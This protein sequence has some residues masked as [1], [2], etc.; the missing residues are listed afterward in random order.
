MS[1]PLTIGLAIGIPFIAVPIILVT[2]EL[3]KKKH[4][5]PTPSSSPNEFWTP[6]PTYSDDSTKN[7]VAIF[8]KK[9]RTSFTYVYWDTKTAIKSFRKNPSDAINKSLYNIRRSIKS[10]SQ[11]IRN[12]LNSI[13]HNTKTV[14]QKSRAGGSRK[15]KIIKHGV[16]RRRRRRRRR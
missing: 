14:G 10:V 12:S 9:L 3:L 6:S 7:V 5:D 13:S 8:A 16:T 11:K 1:D 15:Y 2:G 4:P